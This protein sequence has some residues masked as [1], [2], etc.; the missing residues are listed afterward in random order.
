MVRVEMGRARLGG[1]AIKGFDGSK[2][3][4]EAVL[5]KLDAGGVG[6]TFTFV[7][8]GNPHCV[9]M[10]ADLDSVDLAAEGPP[11]ENH[12]FFPNRTNVEFVRSD[13]PAELTMKVWE[14]GVG[15]TRACGTGACAVAVAAC[16]NGRAESP[17]VV[18]LPGGDLEIEVDDDLDVVMTG[19][20]EEIFSGA[21]SGAF[22]K[23]M[24]EL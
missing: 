11:I 5:E 18:H 22:I 3:K 8:M 2:G 14:R 21:M 7:D 15:E 1:P 13:G 9:I 24:K 17:V 23:R 16:S 19:P 4:G 12:E 10:V 20:A 6:Y